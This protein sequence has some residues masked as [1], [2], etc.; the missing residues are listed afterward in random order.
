MDKLIYY[1]QWWFEFEIP[2][3]VERDASDKI[4]GTPL[5]PVLIGPRRSGK[6]TIFYQ[7]ISKLLAKVPR[8]NV[9]YLNYEDDRLLPLSGNEL[10]QLLDVY[11]QHFKNDPDHKIYLFLDEVQNVPNWERTTRRIAETESRVQLFITGS[12][13]KMLSSDIASALRGRSL[14]YKILPLNF[15][16]FLKFSEYDMPDIAKLQFSSTRHELLFLFDKFLKY[17]GFPQVVLTNSM[18]VKEH[19][20]RE[21]L[22]TIFFADIVERYEIRQVR[23]LDAFIKILTRQMAS[24][25]SI[26]KMANSLKSVGF[27]VSKNTL[28]EY[29]G[30]IEDAFL[31]KSISIYSYSVKDQLQYPRK[32]Y[33]ID[34]GLY[35]A[36]SFIKHEDYG[37]LLENLVFIHLFRKN[38]AIYYWKSS[39]GYEV[40]FVLP[41]LFDHSEHFSLIQVC[42]NF[43]NDGQRQ[44]EIRALLKAAREFKITRCLI[45]TRDAWETIDIE[46]VQIVVKPFIQ[47][48]LERPSEIRSSSL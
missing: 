9:L 33:L 13:S 19:I 36:A 6:S 48:A 24:L 14:S 17:G 4:L 5:I 32:F 34:N 1:L 3:F 27:K 22:H 8:E 42:Y 23:V 44:R 18:Q 43:Q 41:D 35:Q 38:D 28:I 21:Y 12:N 37:H 45:I 7:F 25:F 20:L 39:N 26:G 46:G 15:A 30:Y 47:W 11:R 16:E 31:G 29:L 10:S 2:P 40:D